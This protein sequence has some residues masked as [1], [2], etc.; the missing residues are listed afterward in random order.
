MKSPRPIDEGLAAAWAKVMAMEPAS[1]LEKE[2]A[3]FAKGPKAEGRGLKAEK[4]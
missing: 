1:A 2:S 3:E 4:K